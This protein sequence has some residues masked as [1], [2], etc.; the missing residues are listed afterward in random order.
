MGKCRVC[1]LTEEMDTRDGASFDGDIVLLSTGEQVFVKVFLLFTTEF[2][3][4]NKSVDYRSNM[5]NIM[6]PYPIAD[7]KKTKHVKV[8]VYFVYCSLCWHLTFSV[9][10]P[11]T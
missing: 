9:W 4:E 11:E 5:G 6:M 10:C 1:E 2:T 3:T 8:Y 7:G